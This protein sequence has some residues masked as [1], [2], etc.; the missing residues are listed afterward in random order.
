VK[1]VLTTVKYVL[2]TVK[3]VIQDSIFIESLM[4]I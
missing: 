4:M 1:Y 2:T 3:Y